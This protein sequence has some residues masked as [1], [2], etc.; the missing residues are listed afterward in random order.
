MS[1]KRDEY[2]PL[3]FS[4][5]WLERLSMGVPGDIRAG[6][7]CLTD[8]ILAG[9]EPLVVP[10]KQCPR[11]EAFLAA[12]CPVC[13]WPRPAIEALLDVPTLRDWPRPDPMK[14]LA[15]KLLNAETLADV[16]DAQAALNE[17]VE[18]ES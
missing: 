1:D 11:C 15:R 16:L 14:E 17:F 6:A 2:L 9:L 12:S 8:L 18:R 13:K 10:P 7:R 4:R 3:H 5:E